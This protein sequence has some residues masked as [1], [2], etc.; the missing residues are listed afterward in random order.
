MTLF[1]HQGAAQEP[2][3]FESLY[4]V[5]VMA[6]LEEVPEAGLNFDKVEGRIAHASAIAK[7]TSE[8]DILSFYSQVLPQMGWYKKGADVFVREGEKLNIYFDKSIAYTNVQFSLQPY[9]P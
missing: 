2:L 4:D 6:G 1:P 3:F 9:N 5:P 8:A 7:N